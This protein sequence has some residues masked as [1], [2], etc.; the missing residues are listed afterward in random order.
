MLEVKPLSSEDSYESEE[1]SD[2]EEIQTLTV[3]EQAEVMKFF[4]GLD[5]YV[6]F[7]KGDKNLLAKSMIKFVKQNK[8]FG[9]TPTHFNS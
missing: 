5:K 3:K 1:S 6:R 8:G 9:P 7:I 4:A 2:S